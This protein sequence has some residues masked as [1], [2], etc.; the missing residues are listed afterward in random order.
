LTNWFVT[1]AAGFI[2]SN[3]CAHLLRNGHEVVGLDNFSTGTPANIARVAALGGSRFQFVEGDIL[4]KLLLERTIVPSAVMAHLAAQVSVQHSLDDV[5][6][7]NSINVAGFLAAHS[8]AATV[9][10]RKFLYASSCAV[11]GDNTDL[12]LSEDAVPRP[13]S[14]YAVSKLVNEYY[15]EVLCQRYPELDAIGLRFFNIYGPWQDHRGGYAAV[16]PRWIDALMCGERP[17][18]FGD[19][20][21]TRDFLFVG[22]LAATL[23]RIGT[24]E[25]ISDRRRVF[26]IGTGA[27]TSLIELYEVICSELHKC[28]V[29]LPQGGADFR[30]WRTG[31]IVHSRADITRIKDASCIVAST[32]LARGV[33]NILDEQYGLRPI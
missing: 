19:G 18:L 29:S 15:A 10:V 12:P 28:G 24:S 20:G 4:D 21:A 16:V 13:L 11:Y 27:A 14:P 3:L 8:A 5:A 26:N 22:D 31:D 1:G 25:T 2:G 33:A 6:Y 23:E 32:T 9:G 17:I 7:T 30:A